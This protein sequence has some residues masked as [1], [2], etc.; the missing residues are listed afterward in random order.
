MREIFTTDDARYGGSD[1]H[2]TQIQ[3]T[4]NGF[5]IVLAPLAT[6]IFEVIE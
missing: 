4:P 5:C 3:V 1:K 2:N 6:M